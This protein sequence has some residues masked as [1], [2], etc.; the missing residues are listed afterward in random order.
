MRIR[1][2][3]SLKLPA[4]EKRGKRPYALLADKRMRVCPECK[5]IYIEY[6]EIIKLNL[7]SL[8]L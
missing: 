6:L 4:V 2:S 8:N 7:F 5:Y 1:L 3:R